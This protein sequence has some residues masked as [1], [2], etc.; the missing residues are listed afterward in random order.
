MKLDSLLAAA[1]AWAQFITKKKWISF[2]LAALLL[3]Q[4]FQF[5]VHSCPPYSRIVNL[6]KSVEVVAI[7]L[8]RH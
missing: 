7:H 4:C 3:P 5:R 2:A 6:L 1:A 8:F